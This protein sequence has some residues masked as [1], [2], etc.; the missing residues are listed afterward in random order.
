M[1]TKLSLIVLTLLVFALGWTTGLMVTGLVTDLS[2]QGAE[3]PVSLHNLKN[4]NVE[5]FSPSDFVAE[6]QIH[7]YDD[8]I[9]LD[10]EDARWAK[11]TNTNSMDPF[12][13]T[14]ANGIEVAVTSPGQLH[15]GDVISFTVEESDRVLIHR[16]VGFGYDEEGWFAITKGDNN[17]QPDPIKV[18]FGNIKGVL[19]GVIY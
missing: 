12:F 5:R 17:P 18:R 10:I 6:E 4:G 19:V 11:F 3:S 13:D 14:G 1:N 8:R 9:V 2:S 7:V 15:V 16:I